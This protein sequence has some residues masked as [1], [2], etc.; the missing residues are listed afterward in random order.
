[1]AETVRH[2]GRANLAKRIDSL[3]GRVE[4]SLYRD[5]SVRF[6]L[7]D[8]GALVVAPPFGLTHETDHD[9]LVA[10]PLLEELARDRVVAAVLVRLGGYALGVFDGERLVAS[11]TGARFVKGRHKKGGSSANRFRRRREGQ[12]RELVDEAAAEAA[13]VLGPWRDRVEAVALGGDRAAVRRVLEARLD[14]AWLEPLAVERFFTVPEPR[15]RVLDELP[16]E[17]YASRVVEEAG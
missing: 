12:E 13:R 17:L 9:G 11:K 14:L 3:E 15:R 2:I 10:A 8:G 4:R 7:V 6:E 5:G 16:Y 1:M